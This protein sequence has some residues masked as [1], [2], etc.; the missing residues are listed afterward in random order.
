MGLI[1]NIY[2]YLHGSHTQ[3][4]TSQLKTYLK[5]TYH[6]RANS[7]QT[8]AAWSFRAASACALSK[9]SSACASISRSLPTAASCALSCRHVAGVI[10]PIVWMDPGSRATGGGWG[11]VKEGLGDDVRGGVKEGV[12]G[13]RAGRE[14]RRWRGVRIRKGWGG[15]GVARGG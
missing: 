11:G 6:T 12:T 9:R 10:V 15:E 14:E 3:A 1:N 2:T 7:N 13:G 4:R 5:V 8:W